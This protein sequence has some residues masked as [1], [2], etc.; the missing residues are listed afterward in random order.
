MP[1]TRLLTFLC[2]AWAVSLPAQAVDIIA[3]KDVGV[4]RLSLASARAIFGMRQVKWP[5][6]RL[7]QVFVLPDTHPV[8]SAMC[9][10]R[11]NIYPYQ[12]RKS[13]DRLVFSGMAQ[14]PAE[15]GSEEEMVTRVAAT[16]GAIG[17]VS[18]A[19]N[20]QSVRVLHVE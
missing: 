10:E 20:N 7:I 14:A 3:N 12:L 1:F 9:K 2:V 19:Y 4:S 11:L 17:Y 18:K 16:P 8:H 15:V 6:G 5:D 13:W